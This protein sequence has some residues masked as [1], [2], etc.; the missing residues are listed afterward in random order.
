[1][2]HPCLYS[3]DLWCFPPDDVL[4]SCSWFSRIFISHSSKYGMLSW[5]I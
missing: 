1:L 3:Y 4:P 2:S 5:K